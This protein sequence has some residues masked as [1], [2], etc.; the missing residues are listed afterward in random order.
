MEPSQHILKEPNL[1]RYHDSNLNSK[2]RALLEKIV[3]KRRD[4]NNKN[5]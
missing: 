2:L 4:N 5:I 3:D 1:N